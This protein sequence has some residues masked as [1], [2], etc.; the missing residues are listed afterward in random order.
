MNFQYIE[1]PNKPDYRTLDF[2]KTIFLG[3]SISGSHNWQLGAKDKL[4]Q[5]FNIFNP[6][7]EN[8][9]V[10]N[11]SMEREQIGWEH[12][13]LQTCEIVLFYF[14]FETVAPITLL[15][16]GAA[17]E[18]TKVCSY[19]KIYAAIHP[20]YKRKN[21]VLIQTELRNPK[22]SRNITFSLDETIEQIIKE[23]K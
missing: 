18:Y 21:D 5:Y 6:R 8:F 12:G 2:H 4:I 22:W 10:L 11:A 14:S 23:N 7:R 15:E 9:D 13:W 17:L 1:A 19:Q 16:Y 3:G 20:E